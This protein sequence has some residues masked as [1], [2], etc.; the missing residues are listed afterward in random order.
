MIGRVYPLGNGFK[1]LL[2]YLETGENRALTRAERVA[3]VEFR[4]LP[5]RDLEVAACM[6]RATA[7]ASVSGTREPLYHFS[8]SCA[9]GDPVDTPTLRRIADRTIRDLGL[10]EYEVVVVA[11]RDRSHPHLHFAVNRVHPERGTLWS[12]WRDFYRI[13]RSLRAQEREL[14]LA[15]VPGWLEPVRARDVARPGVEVRDP[16]A[17]VLPRPRPKR[18]DKAFVDDVRARVAAVLAFA[19]SWAEAERGL[20][21]QGLSLVVKGGGFRITDGRQDVKASDVA[22]EFSRYHLEKR[23]GPYPD[24]RARMAVA[25]GAPRPAEPW[26]TPEP[27]NP[28]A[29]PQQTEVA[30]ER[31]EPVRAPEPRVPSV[32]HPAPAD[33]PRAP[34]PRPV[35][36]APPP[37]VTPPQPDPLGDL[38]Q[39]GA[40]IE[41]A[42]RLIEE[43]GKEVHDADHALA[44]IPERVKRAEAARDN[45]AARLR[46][47]YADPS[48]A[49]A[50]ITEF[51]R[52]N[53]ERALLSAVNATPAQF[54]PLRWERDPRLFGI[55]FRK[56]TTRA[57]RTGPLLAVALQH[58]YATPAPSPE[59][60]AAAQR[61]ADDARVAMAAAQQARST[62]P[63]GH[64]SR[65]RRELADVF[66]AVAA[67]VPGGAERLA[68]FVTTT[69]PNAARFV[70]SAL[71]AVH[72]EE[73]RRE[74]E[75]RRPRGPGG[76]DF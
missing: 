61:R 14:G 22:R 7:D 21:G 10:S 45:T 5:T 37:P 18:G 44:M 52:Q 6:M 17:R 34:R 54:G 55:I 53:G 23:F 3:W 13:E 60:R 56:D 42:E 29:A 68:R 66:R 65:Y 51:R 38:V 11:H 59:E 41:E 30:P 12:N 62:L 33:P 43:A 64:S 71:D 75:Q 69:M 48:A 4:N 28:A 27:R 15:V 70:A 46:E 25:E 76:I 26:L 49:L 9:P 31:A 39:R 1:G 58:Y 24:Y 67:E 47:V 20:A 72:E 8:I 19:R 40:A 50:A 57:E 74:R 16:D 63:P 2:S 73:R 36:P 32:P 35:A